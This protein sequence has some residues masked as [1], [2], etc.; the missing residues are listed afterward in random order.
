VSDTGFVVGLS[1]NGV[2]ERLEI[3]FSAIK[4]F[5]DPSVKFAMQFT[6][7]DAEE[8]TEESADPPGPKVVAAKPEEAAPEPEAAP[9]APGDKP[10]ADIVRID[11][12]RKK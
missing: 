1:F 11:R 5:A 3:P 6:E 2:R 10:T 7:L 9:A 8:A 4:S 12:F